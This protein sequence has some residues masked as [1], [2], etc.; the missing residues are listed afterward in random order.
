MPSELS[1][2][3]VKDT[4]FHDRLSSTGG[5]G[6]TYMVRAVKLEASASGTYYNASQGAFGTAID[7]AIPAIVAADK[8]ESAA[9]GKP[10]KIEPDHAATP[11]SGAGGTT[12]TIRAPTPTGLG[13]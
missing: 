5:P 1:S 12:N 10:A 8:V 6:T 11:A 9:A 13:I 3:L 4:I 7:T 2:A